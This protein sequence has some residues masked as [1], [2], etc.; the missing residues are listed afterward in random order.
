M[1]EET[2]TTIGKTIKVQGQITG[3]ESLVI[4]GSVEGEITIEKDLQINPSGNLKAKVNARSVTVAGAITGSIN[5]TEKVEIL[6]GGV[7]VGDVISPRF[8]VRDGGTLN[9]KIEMPIPE[10]RAE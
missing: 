1:K 3:A 8:L 2:L 4:D 9:G 7:V 5:A 6:A 10:K